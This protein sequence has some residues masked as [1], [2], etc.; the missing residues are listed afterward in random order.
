MN[1]KAKAALL[2]GALLTVVMAAPAVAGPPRVGFW[3]KACPRITTLAV[4]WVSSPRIG[5]SLAWRRP[6]PHSARLFWYWP[7]FCQAAG[8]KSL[9]TLANPGARR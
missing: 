6:W 9:I 7:V 2:F 5:L 4:R 3:M 1:L 8:I